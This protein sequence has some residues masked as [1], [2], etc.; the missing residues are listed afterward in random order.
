MYR[1]FNAFETGTLS[2]KMCGERVGKLTSEL[3]A[4][5]SRGNELREQ[6]AIEKPRIPDPEQIVDI[7]NY[8]RGSPRERVAFGTQ[9]PASKGDQRS[10]C[11]KQV[12]NTPRLLDPAGT[13]FFGILST[14]VRISGEGCSLFEPD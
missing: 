12:D 1:Y 9:G 6:V 14:I 3:V 8:A 11:N 4:S 2:E 7:Y 13:F 10:P 5:Q